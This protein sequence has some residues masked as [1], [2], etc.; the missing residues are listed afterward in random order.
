MPVITTSFAA[1]LGYSTIENLPIA[2]VSPPP[3]HLYTKVD[4]PGACVCYDDLPGEVLDEVSERNGKMK[5][6]QI[7]GC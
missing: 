5:K 4:E 3:S 6:L 2:I 7:D 1:P